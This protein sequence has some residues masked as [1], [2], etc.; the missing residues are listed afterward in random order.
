MCWLTRLI[1]IPSGFVGFRRLERNWFLSWN[2]GVVGRLSTLGGCWCWGEPILSILGRWTLL[3]LWKDRLLLAN[4]TRSWGC[5]TKGCWRW[6]QRWNPICMILLP[7]RRCFGSSF[8]ILGSGFLAWGLQQL[9]WNLLIS[10]DF[11]LIRHNYELIWQPQSNIGSWGLWRYRNNQLTCLSC[12]LQR[13]GQ[14]YHPNR[15]LRKWPLRFAVRTWILRHHRPFLANW[16]R[17]CGP[18]YRNF[19]DKGCKRFFHLRFCCWDWWRKGASFQPYQ[20]F[21]GRR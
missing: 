17:L 11:W 8:S 5:L 2:R 7:W 12:S 6:L 21:L 10:W 20:R 16:T 19:L 4:P 13:Q 18:R 1:H 15:G 9:K 3:F 14:F